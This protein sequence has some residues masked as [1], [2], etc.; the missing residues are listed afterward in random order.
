VLKGFSRGVAVPGRV[1]I[2]DVAT[3]AGV[4]IATVS[5]SL[6]GVE[7]ARI[8]ADTRARVRDVADRLGYVPNRLAR[9]LRVQRS[10]TIGFI[11]DTVA[12]T[13]FAV[14]MILG[15]LEAARAAD[16][17]VL[18]MNTEADRDLEAREL[19][20]L[21][22][23]QVDGVLYATMYHRSVEVPAVL[24]DTPVVLVDAES[25]DPTVSSVVP[26]EV[27]G[28]MTAVGELLGY[29]HR[30]IAFI[31]NPDPTLAATGR[32]EGYER[33][34]GRAGIGVDPTL[35]IAAS[36]VGPKGGYRA[37]QQLLELP[38]RPTAVF[39]F[40]DLMAMGVYRAALEAGLDIPGDLSVVGFDDMEFVASALFP[41]LTTVALPHYEMGS[42]G[43]QQLLALME[44]PTREAEQVKLSGQLIRR[45]SVAPPPPVG[46]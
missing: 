29:G 41:G 39:C 15:A 19:A 20:T 28:A 26:D 12:T 45:R 18:L 21:L 43:V 16:R 22:Q 32:L 38:E 11:G 30:R 17:V 6:N 2:S 9:S 23:H 14:G 46:T 34:L 31:N 13:P 35:I 40:R 27:A 5:A 25:A 44:S 24:R 1:R 42:W 4:S 33:A 3:A 8:S 37:A 7:S 10:G 36:E